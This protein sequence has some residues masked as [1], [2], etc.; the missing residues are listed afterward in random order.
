MPRSR[1]LKI[2]SGSPKR[3][4]KFLGFTISN[5]VEPTRQI[6]ER[7]YGSSRSGFGN[8]RV[9]RSASALLDRT[10]VVRTR[11][12]GAVGRGGAA[13]LPP[14]PISVLYDVITVDTLS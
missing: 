11:M 6:A 14:N 3:E 13:R 10:A 1:A 2:S 5:D 7:P 9:G 8:R 4:R 12:P